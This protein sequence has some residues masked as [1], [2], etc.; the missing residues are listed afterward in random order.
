M[1]AEYA[2]PGRKPVPAETSPS[3]KNVGPQTGPGA[4]AE[5]IRHHYDFGNE[6]YALWLDLTMTYSAALWD[7]DDPRDEL[8]AA[9]LR[10]IDHHACQA[11]A[12]L[13]ERVLDI[14][15]GWGGFLRRLLERHGVEKAVGLTLSLE[16]AKWIGD[17]DPRVE[18]RVESWADHEPRQPYN[19]IVSVEGFEALARPEYS[20][21][22]KIAA[23]REFFRRCR[24]WLKPGG[25]LALQTIAYG[26]AGPQDL[27]AF[28]STEIFPESD[29]PTL[30]EIMEAREYLLEV[31]ELRNDRAHYVRTL[32]AWQRRLQANKDRAVQIAGEEEYRR[33]RHYLKLSEYMFETGTCDLLRLT[34]QRIEQPRRVV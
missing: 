31:V 14:G 33:Y 11:G 19:A 34:L 27:D 29:L 22:A 28:I 4:S 20:R 16:Q 18:V 12:H 2:A 17:R 6:F 24:N 25:K 13:A 21:E 30:A 23:Y 1:N 26:N 3:G 7:M 9:Q 15:C 10:K 32:K 8:Q 5:A